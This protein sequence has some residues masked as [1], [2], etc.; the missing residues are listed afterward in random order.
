MSLKTVE[1]Q[2]KAG[3][4]NFVTHFSSPVISNGACGM[5]DLW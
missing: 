2:S 5:R 3:T 1:Y 4:M